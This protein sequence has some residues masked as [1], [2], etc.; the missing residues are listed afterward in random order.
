LRKS[1]V[2]AEK[3]PMLDECPVCGGPF[4]VDSGDTPALVCAVCDYV[5]QPEEEE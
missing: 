3:N 1:S 4:E 5:V 2:Y